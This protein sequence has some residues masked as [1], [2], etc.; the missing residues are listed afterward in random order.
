MLAAGRALGNGGC[1]VLLQSLL[2][3]AVKLEQLR[4]RGG[5]GKEERQSEP[6]LSEVVTKGAGGHCSRTYVAEA[7]DSLLRAQPRVLRDDC[8][9]GST[10]QSSV[11]DRCATLRQAAFCN[12]Y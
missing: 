7:E 11:A 12:L 1:V 9:P 4:F 10:V 6:G 5:N 8:N 2:L 3:Q